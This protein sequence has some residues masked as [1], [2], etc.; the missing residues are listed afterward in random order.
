MVVSRKNHV[1]KANHAQLQEG[2][3][4]ARWPGASASFVTRRKLHREFRQQTCCCAARH[5]GTANKWSASN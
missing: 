2:V 3:E 5:H 1:R 4:G